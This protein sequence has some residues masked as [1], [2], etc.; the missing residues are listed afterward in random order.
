MSLVE[1]HT[2][3]K[4]KLADGTLATRAVVV[5]QAILSVLHQLIYH[6]RP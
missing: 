4:L 6:G 5:C 3:F 2:Y 1:Y